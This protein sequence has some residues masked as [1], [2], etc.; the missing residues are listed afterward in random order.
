MVRREMP[1]H[2]SSAGDFGEKVRAYVR[3]RAEIEGKRL[4]ER[5]VDELTKSLLDYRRE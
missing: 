1:V 4:T 3:R 5:Q 2:D